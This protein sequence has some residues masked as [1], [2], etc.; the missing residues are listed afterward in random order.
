MPFVSRGHGYL[1][2]V[3][4]FGALVLTQLVVDSIYGKGFYSLNAWP[5]Y[6]AVALGS[7]M[8]W[9][10][11]RWL[12]SGAVRRFV[13]PKTRKEVV[14]PSPRH[15]FLFVKVE[16]WGVIGAIACFVSTALWELEIFRP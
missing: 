15:D 1:V 11:G 16:Y 2:I 10:V 12:N 6:V 4:Y 9:I 13:D 14:T 3:F 7:I 8:C 5:K